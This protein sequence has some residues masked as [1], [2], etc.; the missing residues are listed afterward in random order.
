MISVT[1][2]FNAH[3]KTA[4]CCISG[5]MTGN[6]FHFLLHHFS[7]NSGQMLVLMREKNSKCYFVKDIVVQNKFQ[8]R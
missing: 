4:K 5:R 6:A 8:Q 3:K 7:F 2:K 1:Y